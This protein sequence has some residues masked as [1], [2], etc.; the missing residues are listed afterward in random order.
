[1]SFRLSLP[2]GTSNETERPCADGQFG[3]VMKTY[4]DWKLSGDTGWLRELWPAPVE[5]LTVTNGALDA[6][7]RVLA[8]VTR[9]GDR[10]VIENPTF[11]PFFDLIDHYGLE[12]IGVGL[13]DAFSYE[14]EE[15]S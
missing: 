9:Y 12:A 13:D 1:M 3:N 5:A 6:I 7:D 8:N 14:T 4:R 10:I 11:P 15:S 2:L